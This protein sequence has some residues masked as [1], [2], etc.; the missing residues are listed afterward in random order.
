MDKQFE[1]S[2]CSQRARSAAVLHNTNSKM[3]FRI[4]HTNYFCNK[5]PLNATFWS[6][7][8]TRPW[9]K[10][11]TPTG[12][13]GAGESQGQRQCS[14][15]LLTVE[16]REHHHQWHLAFWQKTKQA[17]RTKAADIWNSWIYFERQRYWECL[18]LHFRTE[19]LNGNLNYKWGHL[20]NNCF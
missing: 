17:T 6:G 13:K 7:S 11:V 1:E 2:I 9:L 8:S 5:F 15:L 3:L 19:D 10:Q 4:P 14:I 20:E 12:E 18:V 16:Q